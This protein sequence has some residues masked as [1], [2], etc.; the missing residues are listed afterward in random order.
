VSV[1]S[2]MVAPRTPDRD[3]S[4]HLLRARQPG[5][6]AGLRAASDHSRAAVVTAHAS[7]ARARSAPRWRWSSGPCGSS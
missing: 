6:A 3:Q 5:W 2:R 1:I 4:R 7:A